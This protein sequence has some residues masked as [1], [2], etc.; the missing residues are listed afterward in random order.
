MQWLVCQ[1][2]PANALGFW[3]FSEELSLERLGKESWSHIIFHPGEVF[4]GEEL[5]QLPAAT[6]A[7]L[8]ASDEL[9]C[10][11]EE[12]WRA[13]ERWEGA[14]EDRL[15][16][17]RHPHYLQEAVGMVSSIRFGL[18]DR[19]TFRWEVEVEGFRRSVRFHRLVSEEVGVRLEE[20]L[21]RGAGQLYRC[22]L[23]PY[24]P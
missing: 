2:E 12:V 14:E 13:L 9:T 20:E 8:L 3:Q 10:R 22:S 7:R 15:E 24:L 23:S 1:L 21:A 17:R 6:L 16:V 4:Q 18:M 11:E 5:R 19:D